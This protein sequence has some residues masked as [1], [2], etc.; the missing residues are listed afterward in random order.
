MTSIWTHVPY[1]S[2][3]RTWNL[4]PILD[5]HH[6]QRSLKIRYRVPKHKMMAGWS[7]L[8]GDR[9]DNKVGEPYYRARGQRLTMF[10][11]ASK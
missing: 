6:V 7:L 9:E 1:L 2:F 8:P 3:L 11:L 5:L 4:Q 10:S